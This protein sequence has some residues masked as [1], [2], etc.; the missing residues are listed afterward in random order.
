MQD[1]D[2]FRIQVMAKIHGEF[3][4]EKG[5]TIFTIEGN[6]SKSD[7]LQII[8]GLEKNQVTRDIIWDASYGT[9]ED[10]D[11]NELRKIAQFLKKGHGM[12][13]GGRTAL[14]GPDDLNFGIGR[15]FQA[16]TEAD[17]LAVEYKTFRTMD[18]AKAWLESPRN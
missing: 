18:A 1:M 13:E 16:Y 2:V 12:R 17:N 7:M 8:T 5:L 10:I 6:A 15:M 14:V 11:K 4:P 9:V 3:M